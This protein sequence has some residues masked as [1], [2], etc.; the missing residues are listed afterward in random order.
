MLGH[1]VDFFCS[2]PSMNPL[3]YA[4]ALFFLACTLVWG[5]WW[6]HRHDNARDGKLLLIVGVV[7][8][9]SAVAVG[10]NF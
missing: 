5:A 2:P 10:M 7:T 3:Y 8:G 6:E 1:P 9:L 4:L